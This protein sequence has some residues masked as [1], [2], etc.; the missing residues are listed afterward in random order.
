MEPRIVISISGDIIPLSAFIDA[1]SHIH[2][3]LSDVDK[4]ISGTSTLVWSVESL[5]NSSKI[6]EAAPYLIHEDGVD[7][8]VRIVSAFV[9][10]MQKISLDKPVRPNY[11]SEDSLLR[12]KSLANLLDGYVTRISLRGTIEGK[13]SDYILI[14]QRVAANVD[15]LIGIRRTSLGSIEGKMELISIHGGTYFNIYDQLSGRR[16]KC[17]CNRDQLNELTSAQNLG[18][19]I[20]VYGEIRE[21]SF[22]QAIQI[23]LQH[24]RF[25]R[26]RDEL[27]QPNDLRGILVN[28]T[29]AG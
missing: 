16:I 25:L 23:K 9:E 6:V 27:P 11:F 1:T 13:L 26:N 2:F 12:A 5:G 21:D 28:N 14:T 10:G 29:S 18:R 22:G 17:V 7:N 4:Q 20:L 15:E 24:H 8:R 3:I 19:R